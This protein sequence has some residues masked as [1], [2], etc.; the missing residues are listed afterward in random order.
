MYSMTDYGAADGRNALFLAVEMVKMLLENLDERDTPKDNESASL[1]LSSAEN[2]AQT[3]LEHGTLLLE[4]L[5]QNDW[6]A[7]AS[8]L[9][10]PECPLSALSAAYPQ[11]SF[12]PLL[13]PTSFYIPCAPSNSTDLGITNSAVHWLSTSPTPIHLLESQAATDWLCFW[14]SR[15]AELRDGGM[16]LASFMCHSDAA[17]EGS[18][19]KDCVDPAERLTNYMDGSRGSRWKL[20]VVRMRA[21][22]WIV[23]KTAFEEQIILEDVLLPLYPRTH[24]EIIAPF[25]APSPLSSLLFVR[26]WEKKRPAHPVYAS[27]LDHKD[28]IRYAREHATQMRAFLGWSVPGLWGLFDYQ[29][30]ES[31]PTDAFFTIVEEIL[32]DEE[33]RDQ[34]KFGKGG[35]MLMCVEKVA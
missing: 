32:R 8:Y 29:G 27:F 6:S 4:D 7:V 33:A 1:A 28:P 26:F 10:S 15:H 18:P 30:P 21:R 16:V 12:I 34:F 11:T 35:R 24:E 17:D 23:R 31:G 22:G 5:P 3:T 14:T 2:N 19:G 25:L 9:S 20:P 13:S